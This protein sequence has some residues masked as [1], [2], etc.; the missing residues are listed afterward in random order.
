MTHGS[1][2]GF[3]IDPMK[4]LVMLWVAAGS[5]LAVPLTPSERKTIFNELTA[6]AQLLRNDGTEAPVPRV[7]VE[8]M[9]SNPSK[10]DVFAFLTLAPYED[11]NAR[12]TYLFLLSDRGQG[13]K[14]LVSAVVATG[15]QRIE[16]GY[17]KIADG[18]VWL[19]SDDS[20]GDD[21]QRAFGVEK[22]Y[23]RWHLDGNHLNR[24]GNI[25]L[26]KN[27]EFVEVPGK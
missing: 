25:W 12:K 5:L 3:R 23:Y 24:V 10:Q 17:I 7:L 22:I 14:T 9:F 20:L 18:D 4:V 6:Q 11:P 27:Y 2:T 26:F 16:A 19:C 1:K 13:Y 15:T 21:N 8:E